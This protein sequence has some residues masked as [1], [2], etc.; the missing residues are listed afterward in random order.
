M[1]AINI[2]FEGIPG[3]DPV[4]YLGVFDDLGMPLNSEEWREIEP[5]KWCLRIVSEPTDLPRDFYE[6][7]MAQFIRLWRTQ[8]PGFG[9]YNK[10]RNVRQSIREERNQ[11]Y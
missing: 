4:K 9:W 5:N 10:L 6:G 3:P 2:Y 1:V 11:A 7:A 8:S